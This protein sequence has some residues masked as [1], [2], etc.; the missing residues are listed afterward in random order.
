MTGEFYLRKLVISIVLSR[1]IRIGI[2]DPLSIGKN[3]TTQAVISG[4]FK[5]YHPVTSIG[6]GNKLL[7]FVKF[8]LHNIVMIISHFQ[9]WRNTVNR[10]LSGEDPLIVLFVCNNIPIISPSKGQIQTGIILPFVGSILFKVMLGAV[11]VDIFILCFTAKGSGF[12]RCLNAKTPAAAHIQRRLDF[13]DIV[14]IINMANAQ[15]HFF[16]A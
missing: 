1:I 2:I 10:L 6:H 3:H 9:Q 15:R 8:H 5:V 16:A 12:H 14:A 11:T 4:S 7:V 13:T